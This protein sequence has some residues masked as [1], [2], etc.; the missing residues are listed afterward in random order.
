VQR[1]WETHAKGANIGASHRKEA[2]GGGRI[3]VYDH[4]GGEG[5]SVFKGHA[6]RGG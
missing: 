6:G 3:F 5:K 1:T 4:G 2:G